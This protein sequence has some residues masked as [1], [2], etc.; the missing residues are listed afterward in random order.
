M[1]S[2]C[3]MVRTGAILIGVLH[4][5]F[6]NDAVSAT[7]GSLGSTSTGSMTIGVIKPARANITNMGDLSQSSWS[8]GGGDITLVD[9]ACVYSSRPS[10]GYTVRASGSGSGGAFTLANGSATLEYSVTW[11]SGGVNSLSN[12]GATLTANAVS[13]GLTHAATDSSTCNGATPG[14]TARLIVAISAA[15]MAAAIAGTYTGTL[16]LIVTPN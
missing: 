14:P 16:M 5:L 8:S 3:K 2:L 1:R 6:M 15:N 7:Q 10:G 12:N 11:N 9:D 4:G 13:G